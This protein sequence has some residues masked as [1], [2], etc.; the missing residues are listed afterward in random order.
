MTTEELN[1]LIAQAE[2]GDI[3]AMN[4]LT[5]IYG[6]IGG[7]IDREQAAKW[8]LTLIQ[9]D[10][11]PNSGVYEKTG[12]NKDLYEKI[13]NAI[14]NSASENDMSSL[15][16]SSSGGSLLSG[17]ISFTSSNAKSYINQAEE[18][19]KQNIIYKKG[20]ARRIAAE[21]ARRRAEEEAR[22]RAEEEARRR[23]EEEARRIAKEEARRRAEEEARRRAEEEARK[24][25]EE[26]Q[27]AADVVVKKIDA[28][29]TIAYSKACSSKIG[30]ARLAYDALTTEQKRKVKNIR[31][32]TAAEKK[33]KELEQETKA[34]RKAEYEALMKDPQYI[35]TRKINAIEN[36]FSFEYVDKN[37]YDFF[38]RHPKGVNPNDEKTLTIPD[39]V[40]KIGDYT[41]MLCNS[42]ISATIPDGVRS[43]GER[44]FYKCTNLNSIVIPNSVKCIGS[45]AFYCCTSLNQCNIPNGITNIDR[46]AFAFCNNL[47]TIIIP[48]SIKNIE[49]CVFHQCTALKSIVI[50]DGVT[51]I[52]K[53]A[54]KNCYALASVTIPNTV[55]SIGEDAFEFCRE[56]TS[57]SIPDSVTH[58]GKNAFAYCD[59]LKRI[60]VP[61]GS[62]ERFAAMEG[63]QKCSSLIVEA[64]S[65]KKQKI[66]NQPSEESKSSGF[67]SRLMKDI[68]D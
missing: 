10:C 21:E 52:G 9:K 61:K 23:A 31:S 50:E 24:I 65:I 68:F 36:G 22:R 33:Y 19:I 60:E 35:L 26:N 59:N 11:D 51:N 5:H 25:E 57:V 54:F 8:F 37:I 56:L 27:M 3:S 66:S 32:L 64:D 18:A 28:I 38:S 17:S 45:E 44:A 53:A 34:R 2:R 29:K 63:L 14:L 30:I 48:G 41:Y 16:G 4:Q 46:W 20:E 1:A 6:E 13:K 55:A 58:I 47:T 12:Y 40:K 43:I 7:Y 42:M 62:K 15:F 49:Y 67:F 39:G